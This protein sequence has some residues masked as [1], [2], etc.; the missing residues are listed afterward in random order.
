MTLL[1]STGRLG[2]GTTSP[3][4]KLHINDGNIKVENVTNPTIEYDNGSAVKA[5]T[6]YDTTNETF[7]LKHNSVS[8]DEQLV[9]TS[10]GN[11]GVGTNSPNAILHAYGSTPSGTVFNVEGTNGSLFSVVD[12]LSG[13]LMSVN[14]NAGL[15]VFEVY[16]D[17]SIIAGRFAQNDFVITSSGDIG[18]GTA[19]PSQKLDIRYPAGG[20]MALLKST[21]VADGLLFGDMAYSTSNTYQGIKHAAMSGPNDYMMISEGTNTLIS[22]KANGDVFIRG[23]G[24]NLASE[25][26]VG[27]TE[28]VINENV[29]NLDFR[30]ES[31]ISSY[32]LFVDGVTSNIGI[33]TASPN[34]QLSIGYADA[35]SAKIEFRSTSYARQAM[36]E[37]IDGVSSGDGHLAF[38]TRKI[39][40][41]LE[42]LR[43]TADGN[44]GIGITSPTSKLHVAGDGNITGNVIVGGNLTILGTTVTADVDRMEVEDPIITLGLASGNVVTDTNLDR[45][46]A[47]TRSAGLTAFMGWDTSESEFSLLSSGVAQNSSGN[48][49]PG[50]YGN[51]H[52]G[53]LIATTANFSSTIDAAN[54]GAGVDNSVVILDSDGKLRTDEI[55]SR[56]WGTSLVDGGG[57][58][59]HVA[60]WTDNNTLSYDS[61]Q[62]FWDSTNNRL[63]IGTAVPSE[64]LHVLGT[65]KIGNW[66]TDGRILDISAG[67]GSTASP[68]FGYLRFT[69]YNEGIRSQI[70]ATDVSQSRSWGTLGFYTNGDDGLVER[71]HITKDGNVGI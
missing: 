21:D 71:M 9:L 1:T 20:G 7:V 68:S 48:Y 51:L 19:S 70:V 66:N 42:R 27:S 36:I 65:I 5:K 43:I 32:T 11:V 54:L 64:K 24:N 60:F 67:L 56:V 26:K 34:E 49:I 12:N 18:M 40:N 10:G 2:I 28:V 29:S 57:V 46:L 39:G 59:G 4:Q 33:R 69:G 37:G 61:N 50:T 38:H 13:V 35:S 25:I 45:G 6:Y 16:D 23:G 22:A 47:L 15:P 53:G 44:V 8:G 63:G 41:A 62:L 3:E 31:N 55:D 17:D 14:N 58:A 52:I 30:V